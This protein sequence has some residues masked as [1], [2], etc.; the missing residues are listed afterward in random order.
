MIE[1][2]ESMTKQF[3][4]SLDAKDYENDFDPKPAIKLF[5]RLLIRLRAA[6][7]ACKD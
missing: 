3:L 6:E 4:T 2:Y 1:T 5:E 7:S